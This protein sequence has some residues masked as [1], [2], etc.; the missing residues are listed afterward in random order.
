MPLTKCSL[1]N[2]CRERRFGLILSSDAP[3][4]CP[5]EPGD[6]S[7]WIADQAL[8]WFDQH[9]RRDL[10]WQHHRTPYRVW[11]AEVMLQQ[12]Q[13][14]SVI[15]YFHAFMRRFPTLQALASTD[16]DDV[17]AM[18]TG[19]GY[20]RRARNLH[21]AAKIL[22][23][24]LGGRIPRSLEHLVA[25]PG[26]GRSTAGAILAQ[27]YRLPGV[28]LDANVRR[29]L[30]RVHARTFAGSVPEAKLWQLAISCTPAIRPDDYAQAMMDLGSSV[31]R[32]RT[33][34]CSACPF[35]TRCET[36]QHGDSALS[37][38][39]ANRSAKVKARVEAIAYVV[40]TLDG[41]VLLERR[42]EKGPWGGLWAPPECLG[43]APDW[44]RFASAHGLVDSVVVA[45]TRL[46]PLT[47][48]LSH[49][50]YAITPVRVRLGSRS[51][52]IPL[53]AGFRW[54]GGYRPKHFGMSSLALKL[55]DLAEPDSD[56]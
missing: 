11:V 5:S 20:Y 36:A 14:R 22:Q 45:Q 25:L 42:P 13:V 1:A 8:S 26:I 30:T 52:Q 7:S 10:P 31:C 48:E 23:E 15:P 46:P 21:A 54:H 44:I 28:V 55:I 51:E 24:R 2:N 38:S 17:L 12:T 49:L 34:N 3:I 27:A 50:R 56:P 9:G 35:E 6:L 19:L 29:V 33:P 43:T 47:H 41:Q 4:D 40:L 32:V 16:V 18:W 39:V 37:S 53:P